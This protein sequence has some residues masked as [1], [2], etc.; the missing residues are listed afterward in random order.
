MKSSPISCTNTTFVFSEETNTQTERHDAKKASTS[1]ALECRLSLL[2][3]LIT[4]KSWENTTIVVIKNRKGNTVSEE[5]QPCFDM[6]KIDGEHPHK[7]YI[8]GPLLLITVLKFCFYLVINILLMSLKSVSCYYT[9]PVISSLFT[10]MF[11]YFWKEHNDDWGSL[12]EAAF[13]PQ[14]KIN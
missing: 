5:T 7:Q 6:C 12:V 1:T 11:V 13:Y 14:N 2:L 4:I 3:I 8:I 10:N 9:F